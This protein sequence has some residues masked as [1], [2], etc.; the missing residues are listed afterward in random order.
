MFVNKDECGI[1]F[2]ELP[3]EISYAIVVK[4]CPNNCEGCHSVHNK[5]YDEFEDNF[6]LDDLKKIIDSNKNKVSCIL[7]LGGEWNYDLINYLSLAKLN[8]LKTCLYTGLDT[9]ENKDI[10]SELDYIKIGSYNKDL[11]GLNNPT[12]NQRLYEVVNGKIDK[13]I[14]YRFR[15]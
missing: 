6:T 13:D 12:T 1:T 15:S 8:G 9:F 14:T 5:N 2:S 7:F 3:T 11:G 4:G 10:L